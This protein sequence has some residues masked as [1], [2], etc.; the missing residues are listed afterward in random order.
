MSV[1]LFSAFVCETGS[2]LSCSRLLPLMR[3]Q[4]TSDKASRDTLWAVLYLLGR[5]A[6][7]DPAAVLAALRPHIDDVVGGAD[8]V[9]VVLDHDHGRAVS[10][11]CLEN[12]Q[13][14]L[15]ILRME[16]DGRLIKDEDGIILL[17]AHFGGEL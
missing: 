17:P 4:I 14:R 6:D 13:K 9:K 11:Q 16:A 12:V 1:R 2:C 10:D 7:N 3:P 5:A 8:H 15:H